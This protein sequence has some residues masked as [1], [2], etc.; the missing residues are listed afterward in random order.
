MPDRHRQAAAGGI[1]PEFVDLSI[2]E[3]EIGVAG[4]AI[5][6]G[7][8]QQRRMLQSMKIQFRE[9]AHWKGS[10]PTTLVVRW[11]TIQP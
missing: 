2:V 4:I 7:R 10:V 8:R 3:I 6:T 11:Q 1:E 9:L 5:E